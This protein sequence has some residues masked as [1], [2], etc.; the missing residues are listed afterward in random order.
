M[1]PRLR[2]SR[3]AA[4]A[5]RRGV[6]VCGYGRAGGTHRTIEPRPHSQT[7]TLSYTHTSLPPDDPLRPR[8]G[9]RRL[10]G[11]PAAGAADGVRLRCVSPEAGGDHRPRRRGRE[12]ARDHAHGRGQVA[13]LPDPG[14][15]ARRRR[16][17]RLAAHLADAGPG[18]GAAPAR[19]AG[20]VP[21]LEPVARRAAPGGGAAARGRARPR[22]RGA[23]APD[24][25]RLLRPHG[26][27]RGR[28]LR[29][30]R[31]PPSTCSWPRCASTFPRSP[32][33]P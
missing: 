20:G 5:R 31:G 9:R 21:Q 17:R 18:G 27:A 14:D 10:H 23:R 8:A 22:L 19:G 6:G 13:L 32:P 11:H 28:P 12:R 1:L 15:G 26:G 30:R 24:D 33:S 7:P 4:T 25:R 2:P 3:G 16:R 29:H